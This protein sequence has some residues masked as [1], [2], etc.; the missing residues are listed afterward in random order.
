MSRKNTNV[1]VV[2]EMAHVYNLRAFFVF[3]WLKANKVKF[4][5][6]KGKPIHV[7]NAVTFCKSIRGIIHAAGKVRDDRNTRADPDRIPTIENM[8]YRDP[9]KKRVGPYDSDDIE[10]PIYASSDTEVGL[11]GVEVSKLYRVNEYRDSSK[12]LD[13][14]DRTRIKWKTIERPERWECKDIFS[15]WAV[16]YRFI[17]PEKDEKRKR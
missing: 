16:K 7:V 3:N 17:Q 15:K 9:G 13:V 2:E 8:L 11:N 14:L 5:K 6:V 12:M 4:R 10:R 1:L